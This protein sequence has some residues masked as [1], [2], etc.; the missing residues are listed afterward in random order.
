LSRCRGSRCSVDCS[1]STAPCIARRWRSV[2]RRRHAVGL[3][4]T[5]LEP[6]QHPVLHRAGLRL[7][8]RRSPFRPVHRAGCVRRRYR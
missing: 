3:D 4:Q 7:P 6:P 2:D 1:S 5:A 8:S